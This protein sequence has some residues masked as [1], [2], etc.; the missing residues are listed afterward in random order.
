MTKRE[1]INAL[2]QSEHDDNVLVEIS[3]VVDGDVRWY[4]IRSIE[5]LG[6][7]HNKL[8][9]INEPILLVRGETTKTVD[10]KL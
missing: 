10:W 3:A 2:E 9:D 1:L 6:T 7:D 5:N 8:I 4:V